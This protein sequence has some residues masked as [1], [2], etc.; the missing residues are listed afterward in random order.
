MTPQNLSKAKIRL[1]QRKEEIVRGYLDAK[2]A[3]YNITEWKFAQAEQMGISIHTIEHYL[4]PARL[5]K[6]VEQLNTV[7][8]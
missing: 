6:I 8:A 5:H 7:E 4:R 3:G 1:N 2:Q